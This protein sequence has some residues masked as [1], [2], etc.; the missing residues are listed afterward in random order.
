[1]SRRAVTRVNAQVAPKYLSPGGRASRLRG[2][3]STVRRIWPTRRDAPA[4]WERR[5]GDQ[6]TSSDWR[7][8]PRPTA[9]AAEPCPS[10]NQRSWEVGGRREGD[11]GVRSSEEAG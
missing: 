8:P 4:G 5:H 10:Y 11:G 1:M 3:G 2:E 6:D 7:S 9:K